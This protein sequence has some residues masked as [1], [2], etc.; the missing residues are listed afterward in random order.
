MIYLILLV[1]AAI[2]LIIGTITDIKKREVP[3]WISFA[4]IFAGIGIRLLYSAVTF[5]WMFVL[6]GAAGLG[7]FIGL[8]Y[9]MFYAGQWGGGDA[10]ILMGIGALIVFSVGFLF[11]VFIMKKGDPAMSV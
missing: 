8:G 2:I 9:M 7:I 5:D 10:K 1:I 4:A 6:Y 11:S 3:D